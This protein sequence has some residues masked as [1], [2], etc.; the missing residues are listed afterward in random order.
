MRSVACYPHPRK[1]KI[2]PPSKDWGQAHRVIEVLKAYARR[3]PGKPMP[4][5]DIIKWAWGHRYLQSDYINSL[6]VQVHAARAILNDDT[7]SL[8]VNDRGIGYYWAGDL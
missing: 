6:R 8:I 4:H 1:G 7:R 5:E 2:N 3:H